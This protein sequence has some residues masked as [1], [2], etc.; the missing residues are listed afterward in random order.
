M[1]AFLCSNK[2]LTTLAMYGAR[3][4]GEANE[5]AQTLFAM[6]VRAM[7]TRYEDRWRKDYED[8]VPP[9]PPQI[10]SQLRFRYRLGPPP[11][12]VQIIKLCACY[13]YQAC[14]AREYEG[15]E[16]KKWIDRIE[17]E[18]ISRL[19]GYEESPWSI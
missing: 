8:G 18:A 6:N 9:P 13:D 2:H 10:T 11:T 19:P 1:S 16:A 5:I 4:V 17:Y 12:P 14:E 15:S 3:T 7:D